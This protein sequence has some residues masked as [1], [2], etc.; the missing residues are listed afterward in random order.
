MVRWSPKASI[1]SPRIL[2]EALA[3]IDS[4]NVMESRN[5]LY[6]FL[7]LGGHSSLQ[8]PF[9]EYVTN[10]KHQWQVCIGVPYGTSLWQVA[11]LKEQNGSYKIALTHAKK[12]NLKQN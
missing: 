10:E 12:R 7:L 5:G 8:L 9:L 1:T 6:P 4:F 11:D 3:H 2:V